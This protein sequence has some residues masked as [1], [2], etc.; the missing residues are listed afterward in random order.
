MALALHIPIE[1]I[2]YT[3]LFYVTDEDAIRREI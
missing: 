3:L 2:A 1:S